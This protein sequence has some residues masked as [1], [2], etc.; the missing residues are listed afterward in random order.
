[1]G[2]FRKNQ[3]ILYIICYKIYP[4]HKDSTC[5]REKQKLRIPS[6]VR[7]YPIICHNHST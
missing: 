2:A 4:F 6:Y 7:T 1:M 5:F 3:R